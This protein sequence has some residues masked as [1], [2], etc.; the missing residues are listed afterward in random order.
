MKKEN[1][2]AH[3]VVSLVV[4]MLLISVWVMPAH[5]CAETIHGATIHCVDV[6][7]FETSALFVQEDASIVGLQVLSS[8]LSHLA[9]IPQLL[10][11]MVY[12]PPQA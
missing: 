6:D 9:L 2:K 8:C 7:E 5:T 3:R 4:A 10:V 12:R 11:F 1:R